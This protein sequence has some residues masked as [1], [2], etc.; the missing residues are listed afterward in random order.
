MPFEQLKENRRN[1]ATA[2]RDANDR[3][4]SAEAK[5][6]EAIRSSD[7]VCDGYAAEN[8]Q[9]SDEITRL[10]ERIHILETAHG[11]M[12]R[13]LDERCAR[14]KELEEQLHYANGVADLAMKH[15]DSAEAERTRAQGD[16]LVANMRC[17]E[18][19]EQLAA[20]QEITKKD[21]SP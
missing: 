9:F 18:A 12:Q 21:P 5:R 2:L 3:A 8:Q 13:T 19:E 20:L 4:E 6:D 15:R 14:V 7:A 1:Y 17:V 11:Q 10:R 16:M